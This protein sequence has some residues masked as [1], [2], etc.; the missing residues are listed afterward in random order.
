MEKDEEYYVLSKE[1]SLPVGYKYVWGVS[2]NGN[3]ELDYSFV[4][5]LKVAG[6]YPKKFVENIMALDKDIKIQKIVLEDVEPWK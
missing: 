6:W 5:Q 4:D 1:G 2:L 3:G